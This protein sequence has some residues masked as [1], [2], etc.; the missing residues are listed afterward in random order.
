MFDA[1]PHTQRNEKYLQIGIAR[2][3]TSDLVFEKDGGD[4]YDEKHG[5][6]RPVKETE[7]KQPAD[8][9]EDDVKKPDPVVPT[10]DP[11]DP[12]AAD[13]VTDDPE[14]SDEKSLELNPTR[15]VKGKS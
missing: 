13:P 5:I 10:T 14:A 3:T 4:I 2:K 12:K 8:F 7:D 1:T 15:D 9:K 6:D 11:V